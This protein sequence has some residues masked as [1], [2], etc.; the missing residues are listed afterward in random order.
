MAVIHF[1]YGVGM[2]REFD[3][4]ADLHGNATVVDNDDRLAIAIE[5]E[6]K[7]KE[8]KEIMSGLIGAGSFP[9]ELSFIYDG[10]WEYLRI[11]GSL[12]EY[13]AVNFPDRNKALE[14]MVWK[15]NLNLT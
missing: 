9:I 7:A 5:G 3:I 11:N 15:R 13:G 14:I 10:V 12:K 8:L 2:S 1:R 6:A 4:L